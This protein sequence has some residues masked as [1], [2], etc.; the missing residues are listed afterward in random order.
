MSHSK[1]S[2]RA[3]TI[4]WALLAVLVV[5]CSKKHG[6]PFDP[7]GGHPED[8]FPKHSA[9]YRNSGAASCAECHGDDLRGG[10]A[11]L[12][13]YSTSRDGQACHPGGPDGHPAGADWR[14]QH[15]ADRS[16]AA[17]CAVCHDN[18]GN[19]RVPNCFDNSLCHGP[20][21]DHPADWLRSHSRTN[22]NQ[23]SACTGCHQTN[24]GAPGCFNNTL[25][26]GAKS[27]H[28]AG[29]LQSHPRTDQGEA[30]VCVGCHRSNPGAPGC[31]NNTL[32]H[33][34]KSP[35][36]GGW[37]R[38]HP[39]ADQGQASTCAGC[40]QSSAGTPGC[41]NSTL[42]HG[43]RSGR[44]PAGWRTLHRRTNQSAAAECAGCHAGKGTPSC[45]AVTAA[46]ITGA[47]HPAGWSAGSQHGA[48]A[49]AAS[50]GFANCQTCHGLFLDGGS[51]IQTCHVNI[52]CHGWSAPH[53]SA[54]WRV[55]R[56]KSTDQAN[57]PVCA[58]CH[59]SNP[60]TP[61]CFNI[62]LCHGV[63]GPI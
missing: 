61:G 22:Q 17:E 51:S 46:H 7:D 35:H 5:G 26:H 12:S 34:A 19:N 62:T 40:H 8:F 43:V 52:G 2:S 36:P 41:F 38:S 10:I 39:E 60:G 48:A 27:Y 33:G 28:P 23:A 58:R 63:G 29:W 13:C 4:G 59:Q 42:C 25:C 20:K 21:S 45:F 16:R 47:C 49:K 53:A 57:A 14:A 44:H 56:H 18:K 30:A 50:P 37:L 32:C 31:F 55:S 6:A 15:A 3:L 1:R 11:T 24:A 54:G 9:E